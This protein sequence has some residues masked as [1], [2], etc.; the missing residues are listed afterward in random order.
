ALRPPRSDEGVKLLA[1]AAQQSEPTAKPAMLIASLLV[2][3]VLQTI[4]IQSLSAQTASHRVRAARA[5]VQAASRQETTVSRLGSAPR[6]A[7]RQ[8]TASL[9]RKRPQSVLERRRELAVMDK[10]TRPPLDETP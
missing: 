5:E 6:R 8:R 10:S 9:M 4:P 3:T 2:R 1:L 7:A